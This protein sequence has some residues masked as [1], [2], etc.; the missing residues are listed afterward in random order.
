MKARVSSCCTFRV[1]GSLS[2]SW[3]VFECSSL[4]FDFRWYP[5][6]HAKGLLHIVRSTFCFSRLFSHFLMPVRLLHYLIASGV[7]R[8]PLPSFLSYIDTYALGPSSDMFMRDPHEHM[9]GS[10]RSSP[11]WLLVSTTTASSLN[12]KKRTCSIT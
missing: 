6:P 9:S 5:T 12:C 4:N 3:T 2:P 11:A 10:K 7:G 8:A 1:M